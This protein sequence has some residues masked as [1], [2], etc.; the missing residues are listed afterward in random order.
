[1]HLS[2]IALRLGEAYPSLQLNITTL[3]SHSG[4]PYYVTDL[5]PFRKAIKAIQNIPGITVFVME[6]EET[7]IFKKDAD[8]MSL[9]PDE[10]SEIL[11]RLTDVRNSAFTIMNLYGSTTAD[12]ANTLRIKLPEAHDFDELQKVVG[13]LKLAVE[14]P[15]KLS[16]EEKDIDI[17]RAEPGSIYLIVTLSLGA[18]GLVRAIAF[19]ALDVRQKLIQQSMLI[20]QSQAMGL[21]NEMLAGVKKVFEDDMQKFVDT[22]V[23]KISN[24]YFES[25][26]EGRM[27]LQTSVNIFGDLYERDMQI[28]YSSETL[29]QG[30]NAFP[31]HDQIESLSKAMKQ[32]A[33]KN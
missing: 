26:Q 15:I 21:K 9:T 12:P 16:K 13:Q 3:Q 28:T 5:I 23:D 33:A 29:N 14:T 18:I 4:K 7:A 25:K 2:E 6:L 30:E 24:E 1:M 31:T 32:I 22:E 27:A 8:E 20:K 10:Y 11:N 17:L 19:L